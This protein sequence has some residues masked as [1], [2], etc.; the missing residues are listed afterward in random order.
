M[1]TF[2][3]GKYALFIWPAFALTG[4]VLVWMVAD[5]LSRARYWRRRVEALEA[6]RQDQA[7][8]GK[9]ADSPA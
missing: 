5:T 9:G 6:K 7:A 3:Y 8:Q 4:A 2:D 1:M